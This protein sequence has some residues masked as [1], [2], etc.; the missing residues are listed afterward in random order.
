MVTVTVRGNDHTQTLEPL[1]P[2]PKPQTLKPQPSTLNIVAGSLGSQR[3]VNAICFIN[4]LGLSLDLRPLALNPLGFPYI[5]SFF[6]Y[7]KG[8]SLVEVL[9]ALNRKPSTPMYSLNIT[10]Y[11]SIVFIFLSINPSSGS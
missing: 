2:K 6:M 5:Y 1:K 11:C 10:L 9:S 4:S 8:Y 7:P 3:V